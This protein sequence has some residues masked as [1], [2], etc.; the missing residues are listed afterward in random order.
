MSAAAKRWVEY[1]HLV[2]FGDTNTAGSVY[3][4]KYFS[5][6]GEFRERLLA[7]FYPEFADD[8]RRGFSMIT[9]SAH[10]DFFGEA[11][12]F[13]RIL[14]RLTVTSLTRSRIEFAFEFT[15]KQDGKL[16]AHGHQGVI[17]TNQQ[18][19]PSLMPDKLFETTATYFGFPA[20]DVSP[21]EPPSPG[22][23]TQAAT[24]PLTPVS[25]RG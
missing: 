16:L 15:R 9:E 4:A 14:A 22:P 20:D 18:R 1:D 13:D 2:T 17:W 3:F 11:A 7:Q 23:H 19:R 8:L 12:L 10:L 6:Q 5:W 21:G 25:A 24:T